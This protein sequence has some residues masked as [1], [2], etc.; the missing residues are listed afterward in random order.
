MG[1]EVER[2]DESVSYQ[3]IYIYSRTYSTHTHIVPV[4]SDWVSSREQS[5]KSR[6]ENDESQEV[7]TM[8]V[9]K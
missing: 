4:L 5:R 1:E 3:F 6:S 2:F 9:K 7:R 8:K